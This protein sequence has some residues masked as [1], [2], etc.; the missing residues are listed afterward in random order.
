KDLGAMAFALKLRV[1]LLRDTGAAIS[2]HNAF[3]LL[4]GLETLH[5][6]LERHNENALKTAKFLQNHPGVEWVN[7]PGLKN[8]P[9][10]ELANKYVTS[11]YVSIITFVI[12]GGLEVSNKL[13]NNIEL[14]LH[15]TNV[16]A[17]KSLI[18]LPASTTHQQLDEAGL[19]KS[20]V[21]E[22]LVKLA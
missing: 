13:I 22:E 2:P 19:K 17:A 21:N 16:G 14:W 7:F 1:Q 8:H 11:G 10:H 12:K 18:I 15:V 5:V 3:L 4:Q 9:S 6:R 20:G